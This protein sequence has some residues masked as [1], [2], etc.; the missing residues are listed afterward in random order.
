MFPWIAEQVVKVNYMENSSHL[1]FMY[2]MIKAPTMTVVFTVHRQ[3]SMISSI[4]KE[5]K[6]FRLLMCMRDSHN[7]HKKIFS[8]DKKCGAFMHEL[9]GVKKGTTNSYKQ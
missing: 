7:D 4:T 6:K 1:I 9:F 8:C 3:F 2:I 5:Q